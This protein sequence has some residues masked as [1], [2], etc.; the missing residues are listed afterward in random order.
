MGLFFKF[1][2]FEFKGGMNCFNF[3]LKFMDLIC[4]K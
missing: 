3:I 2:F 4:F 1:I